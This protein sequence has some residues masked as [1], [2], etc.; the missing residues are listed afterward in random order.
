MACCENMGQHGQQ[1]Q[2]TPAPRPQAQPG[3]S[4]H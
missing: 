3:H 1:G 2:Q 4:G